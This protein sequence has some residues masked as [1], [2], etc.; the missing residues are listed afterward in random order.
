MS[1]K[2]N[3]VR[4][5]RQGRRRPAVVVGRTHLADRAVG[6]HVRHVEERLRA[7]QPRAPRLEEPADVAA[8]RHVAAI[9]VPLDAH[10]RIPVHRLLEDRLVVRAE[11]LLPRPLRVVRHVLQPLRGGIPRLV[12]LAVKLM[13][14]VDRYRL[15]MP[16]VFAAP[17]GK[18]APPRIR[19][20]PQLLDGSPVCH[21]AADD[22]G[23]GTTFLEIRERTFKLR[24]ARRVRDVDVA[25]H[26]EPQTRLAGGNAGGGRTL[27]DRQ[28]GGRTEKR[29]PGEAVHVSRPRTS[30][31]TRT[32]RGIVRHS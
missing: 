25:D 26:A 2:R 22:D 11:D 17:L 18:D 23:V 30:R 4:K 31:D 3:R 5:L 24:D 12:C 10:E 32:R 27:N 16:P 29:P 21:V 1:G 9:H 19:R 15:H 20:H 28:G 8:A 13:V 7:S 6:M 14:A